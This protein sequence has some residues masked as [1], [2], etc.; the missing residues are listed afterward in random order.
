MPPPSQVEVDWISRV[1]RWSVDGAAAAAVPVPD[2]W[3]CGRLRTWLIAYRSVQCTATLLEASYIPAATSPLQPARDGG[4]A[5]D[6]S[7]GRHAAAASAL[8]LSSVAV[9]P[10][11]L[12]EL[13]SLSALIC[14]DHVLSVPSSGATLAPASDDEEERKGAEA[15]TT[16]PQIKSQPLR[17]PAWLPSG[18][19]LLVDVHS[20]AFV[21]L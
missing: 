8:Q 19:H 21:P 14:C 5:A 10:L 11:C 7:K 12:D 17:R 1:V 16:A 2:D 6:S 15:Q 20:V 3:T 9:Q 13:S 4:G 18:E